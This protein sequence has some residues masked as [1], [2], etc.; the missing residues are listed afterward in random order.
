MRYTCEHCRNEFEADKPARFCCNAHR[1]AAHRERLRRAETNLEGQRLARQLT[2]EKATEELAEALTPVAQ[3]SGPDVSVESPST[4]PLTAEGQSGR[5]ARDEVYVEFEGEPRQVV[6]EAQ[7]SEDEYIFNEVAQT[8]LY[9]EG[10]RSS[11]PV[12]ERLKRTASYARWRYR[13]F[14]CGEIASL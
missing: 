10:I 12:E 11:V 7:V 4:P 2:E 13:G 8:R 5:Q 3:G 6:R 9:V 14:L 1:Q